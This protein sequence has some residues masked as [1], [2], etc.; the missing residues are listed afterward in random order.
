MFILF[1]KS[2]FDSF[3]LVFEIIPGDYSFYPCL[4]EAPAKHVVQLAQVEVRR[5]PNTTPEMRRFS[6]IR[7]EDAEVGVHQV[8][9]D[10]GMSCPLD[11]EYVNLGDKELKQFPYIKLSTWL[12]YLGIR[13][14]SRQLVGTSSLNKMKT[15]LLEFWSRYEKINPQHEVFQMAASQQV[16]LKFTIP[17]FS[18]SDEGRSYKKEALWIFSCHGCIGRG[19]QSYLKLQKHKAK[20]QRNQMGLNFVGNSWSNQFLIATMLRE[21][22]N[23]NPDALQSLLSLFAEDAAALATEGIFTPEGQQ[24]WFIHLG[25]K[26]DLPALSKCGSFKRSFSHCPRAPS[27]KKACGGICHQCL[28]GQEHSVEPAMEAFPYEDLSEKPC[29][30]PTRDVK[31]P[32]EVIPRLLSGQ[33]T[34]PAQRSRFFRFDIWHIFH[35]GVAKHFLGSAFVTIVESNLP[36]LAPYRSVDAKFQFL[37]GIYKDYCKNKKLPMWT[38]ELSRDAFQWPQSSAQPIGKWNKGSASSTIMLFLGYFCERYITG[39]TELESLLLI[40]ACF[41]FMVFIKFLLHI[42]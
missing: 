38:R 12:K 33:P 9:R 16:Q 4:A 7:I 14:I 35:L 17:Y 2:C 3:A 31:E 30:E 36:A 40:A 26:G 15:V 42:V 25:T 1:F 20:L 34:N 18:H 24:L 37:T 21:L 23:D 29:W 32:W 22:S 41:V 28:A 11:I 10:Y 5:N 39:H 19:T 8:L 27:S 13:R 6:Q